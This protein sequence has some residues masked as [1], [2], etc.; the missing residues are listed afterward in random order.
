MA[1]RRESEAA[2]ALDC[3]SEEVDARRGRYL[4]AL[5]ILGRVWGFPVY[6]LK[7]LRL[8]GLYFGY[9]GIDFYTLGFVKVFCYSL[10]SYF[11]LQRL[12]FHI[13]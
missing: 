11:R 4:C 1:E 5:H 7:S 3:I 13:F 6:G 12:V 2:V 8:H 9:F 10:D